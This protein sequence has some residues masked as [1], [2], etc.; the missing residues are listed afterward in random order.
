M[1][2]IAFSTI[3]GKKKS[4]N[5]SSSVVFRLGNAGNYSIYGRD[6]ITCSLRLR[7]VEMGPNAENI[8]IT[9]ARSR[10]GHSPDATVKPQ[11]HHPTNQVA[12][13][14]CNIGTLERKNLIEGEC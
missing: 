11:P 14:S 6:C 4:T 9:V 5:F 7:E 1:Y 10:L 2:F 13:T 3:V 8:Q 12:A